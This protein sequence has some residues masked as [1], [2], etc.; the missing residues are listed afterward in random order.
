[1]KPECRPKGTQEDKDEARERSSQ[2]CPNDQDKGHEEWTRVTLKN[3]NKNEHGKKK[4]ERR[5]ARN[6]FDSV[7]SIAPRLKGKGLIGWKFES[8]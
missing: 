7:S 6:H 3:E 8:R 1:M 2:A 4:R 5:K